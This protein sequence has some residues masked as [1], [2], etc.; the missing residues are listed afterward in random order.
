M[1]SYDIFA[2]FYD[3]VMGDPTETVALLQGLIREFNPDAKCILELACGTG[4]VLK[5]FREKYQLAGLDLSEGMLD[6]ARRNVP[7]ATFYH[8]D[9]SSFNLQASFDVILCVFDSI[10]HL[11]EFSQWQG[12]FKQAH[13]HL[14]TAGLLI[15]DINTLV[16]LQ[17][18]SQSPARVQEFDGSFLIMKIT[19][20]RNQMYNWS[21][22]VFESIGDNH[23]LLHEENILE[24]SFEKERI[25]GAVKE[26][27]E[28]KRVFDPANK[29]VSPVSERLYF[30]CQKRD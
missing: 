12:L 24:T 17:R 7:E 18:L 27:F 10:N 29:S 1:A 25:E 2:K 8:G 5:G 4:A 13:A 11:A 28:V 6:V 22:R 20:N 26:Y 9:M 19:D 14:T 3:A 21:L 23:Y 16:K 15:F 30:V